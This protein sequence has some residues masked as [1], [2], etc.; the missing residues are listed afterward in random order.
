[1]IDTTELS[2]VVKKL[3][4][5]EAS[6]EGR[7]TDQFGRSYEFLLGCHWRTIRALIEESAALRQGR[8]ELRDLLDSFPRELSAY[9]FTYRGN[10]AK[11][12]NGI[13]DLET[14]VGKLRADNAALRATVK[15]TQLERDNYASQLTLSTKWLG[16]AKAENAALR[17]SVRNQAGDNLCWLKEDDPLRVIVNGNIQIPPQDEFLESCRRY[18]AQ[19]SGKRG[20]LQGAKTIAQLE[21]ENSSLKQQVAVECA[22]YAAA[23]AENAALRAK[24]EAY[25]KAASEGVDLCR[26][27]EA[28]Q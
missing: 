2:L 17:M 18:H 20:E 8:Q 28:H 12:Y 14:Q 11:I 9:A 26:I 19:I 21:A 7:V 16:E 27:R 23:D 25:E 6:N 24:L 1:M 15:Q 10:D 22:N 5:I 3:E 13:Y 4:D